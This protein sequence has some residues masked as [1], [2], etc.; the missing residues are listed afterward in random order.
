VPVTR[1]TSDARRNREVGAWWRVVETG[2]D[3][4]T[5]SQ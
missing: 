2:C 3:A 5:P 1:T 4:L